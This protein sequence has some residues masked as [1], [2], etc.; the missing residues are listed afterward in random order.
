MRSATLLVFIFGPILL[1]AQDPT[2][3]VKSV[4]ASPTSAAS[5]KEMFNA[6]CASCH[7]QDGKGNGPAAPALKD[8]PADLTSLARKNGGKFPGMAVMTSIENGGT[9]AHGSKDMPVWG[10]VLMSVSNGRTLVVSQRISNLTGY[11]ESLQSK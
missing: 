11:I 4:S 1:P 9:R 2:I 8:M 7:G 5:G 3:K 10:P 6:Y